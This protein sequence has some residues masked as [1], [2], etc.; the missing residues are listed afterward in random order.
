MEELSKEISSLNCLLGDYQESA[1]FKGKISA[2]KDAIE[3][4]RVLLTLDVSDGLKYTIS[5][6]LEDLENGLKVAKHNM[7]VANNR[8]EQRF[9]DCYDWNN[10]PIIHEKIDE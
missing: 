5:G 9:I 4:L 2:Y 8:I 3:Q 7:T 6:I 1:Y 10:A